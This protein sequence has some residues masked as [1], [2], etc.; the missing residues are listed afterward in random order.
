MKHIGQELFNI[1]EQ[2]RLVKK[3]I[4]ERVGITPVYFSAIMRK[5]SIDAELLEKI[6]NAIGVSPAYFFDDYVENESIVCDGNN[7]VGMRAV[8]AAIS[9]REIEL[10][11]LMLEEKE[12]TIKILM[13]SKGFDSGQ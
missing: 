2:R 3:E 8:S 4:A 13:Q 1:I 12:R 6:C 9:Q 11:K 7:A 5:G 10:L